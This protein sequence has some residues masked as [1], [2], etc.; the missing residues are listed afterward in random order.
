MRGLLSS[1][2][3]E[4]ER[5]ARGKEERY[6]PR[7]GL[8]QPERRKGKEEGWAGLSLGWAEVLGFFSIFLLPFYSQSAQI[9]LNSNSYEI[10]QI[11]LCT[12][13]NATTSLNLEKI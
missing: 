7:E 10:K 2:R 12:S 13:M 6:G 5:A 3:G 8:G 11:K 4:R 9:Y 1:A